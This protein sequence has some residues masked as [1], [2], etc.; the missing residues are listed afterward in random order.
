MSFLFD[1]TN[2]NL[3]GTLTSTYADP[4]T[5]ACFIKVTNHP[6]AQ[7]VFVILGNSSSSNND[8]Y[9]IRSAGTDDSWSAQSTD[10][11]AATNAATV[12]SINID[13]VWAG[14]VGVFSSNTLRDVY[15]QSLANTATDNNNLVVAD[16]L[17]FIRCGEGMAGG[18]DFVGRIAE[19]AIWNVA[20]SNA[21]I[22]SYMAGTA[23]SGIEAAN[24]IE[25]VS[26]STNSLLNLGTDAGGDLT[27]GGNAVFDADHPIITSGTP[28][29]RMLMTGIG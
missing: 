10:S 9:N 23:A 28:K 5:I 8:S 11:V 1:G 13:G 2:D 20:L 15:V 19:L 18:Q 29:G 6:V 26:M 27:A 12:A 16:V 21:S 7:D 3:T 17:Q 4:V 25:Y 14:V 24:L 22:T